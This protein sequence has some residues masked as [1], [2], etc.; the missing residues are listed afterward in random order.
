MSC[1]FLR[2]KTLLLSVLQRVSCTSNYWAIADTIC[3]HNSS[4]DYFTKTHIRR[5]NSDHDLKL[6]HLIDRFKKKKNNMIGCYLIM[7]AIIV[8]RKMVF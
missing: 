4:S 2:L 7:M 3:L 5:N 1:T 8:Q 6:N